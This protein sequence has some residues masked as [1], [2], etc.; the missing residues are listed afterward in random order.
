MN[1][2]PHLCQ[3]QRGTDN[4]GVGHCAKG[5]KE[6]EGEVKRMPTTAIYSGPTMPLPSGKCSTNISIFV[7]AL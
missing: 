3:G 5:G 1:N 6:E 2:L 7:W 4:D